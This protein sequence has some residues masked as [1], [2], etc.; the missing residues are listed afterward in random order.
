MKQS[1]YIDA[2][3]AVELEELA[4]RFNL[5]PTLAVEALILQRL[6]R[7]GTIDDAD[8]VRRDQ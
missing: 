7:L 1:L 2:S 3:L 8:R 5:T 6:G 4:A